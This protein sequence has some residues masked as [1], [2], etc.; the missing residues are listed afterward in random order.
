VAKLLRE[1]ESLIHHRN[2]A[3][4]TPLHVACQ[5]C[6]LT[7][8]RLLLSYGAS[9]STQIPSR[10]GGYSCMHLVA[11]M[12]AVEIGRELVKNGADISARTGSDDSSSSSSLGNN[13]S[14]SGSVGAAS[15]LGFGCVTAASALPFPAT[16]SLRGSTPLIECAK[17]NSLHFARWLLSIPGL[18][19]GAKDG[20]GFSAMYHAKKLGHSDM[21]KL[22]TPNHL[23]PA[24]VITATGAKFDIWAQL[25]SEPNYEQN[26]AAV[27]DTIHKAEMKK[28]KKLEALEKKQKK[29]PF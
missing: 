9:V 1:D 3:G 5:H 11:R 28:Q 26:L 2:A 25:K 21:V 7:M 12:D 4:Y 23:T 24:Q 8:V 13:G 29:R 20:A 6:N 22:L 19:L 27:R 18:E 15:S 10:F 16:P 17:F 14:G